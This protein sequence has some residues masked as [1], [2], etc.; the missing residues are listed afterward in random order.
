M[1]EIGENT[2][3]RQDPRKA[4]V[5]ARSQ[6]GIRGQQLTLR[7]QNS[8][9]HGD[10]L[11]SM[12][13]GLVMVP[14]ALFTD[15]PLRATLGIPF[16]LFLP[17]Y[18]L[19]AALF[20]RRDDLGGPERLV[21]SLG[22]SLALLPLVGIAVNFTPWGIRLLPIVLSLAM[23][24]VT[25]AG[26]AFYRRQS[27]V[28]KEDWTAPVRSAPSVIR[29]R[30]REQ[31][32][33]ARLFMVLLAITSVGFGATLVTAMA[34]PRGTETF[35]EFYLLDSNGR[36]D[37]YPQRLSPGEDAKV[38]L[39]VISRENQT[40]V[41]HVDVL[42]DGT[43]IREVS[44]F[45]LDPQ[46]RWQQD[47]NFGAFSPGRRQMLQFLLYRVGSDQPYRSLHLWIDALGS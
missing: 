32:W 20:P 3:K 22:L 13:L 45:G 5:P 31:G 7:R 42:L 14:L 19:V 34:T 36:A 28:S 24:I 6:R 43:K 37:S 4:Q 16:A 29:Q 9:R 44:P 18:T 30:W 33:L 46:G 10:L 38:T 35:T 11:I 26:F 2:R 1:V 23:V 40:T 47:V 15:G 17:G 8:M 41:Y 12:A 25:Q 39:G 21:Y 27:S